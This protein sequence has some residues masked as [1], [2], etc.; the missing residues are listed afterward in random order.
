[1]ASFLSISVPTH[2]SSAHFLSSP[3]IPMSHFK[4]MV[5]LPVKCLS[6]G[7]TQNNTDS[8]VES[9]PPSSIFLTQKKES[10]SNSTYNLCAAIGSLGF[11][12]TGYLTYLKVTG[13]DAFCPIGGGNCG[14]ILNSD[15]AA[16]FGVP[17]PLIGMFAY[18]LVATLGVQLGRQNSIFGLG[19]TDGRM[20]LTATVTSMATASAYFLYI[21]STQFSGSACPYCLLS[22]AL[23]ST[24]FVAIIKDLGWQEIQKSVG[25][26]ICVAG[27][28]VAALN[29]SY[30]TIAPTSN[31]MADINLP[32]YQTEITTK[33]TPY[34]ISLAKHLRSIG[35]KMYGAFWCSH[36]LEQK[37]MFGQEGAKL[38]N[39]VE[40]FPN[41]FMKGTNMALECAVARL[42]G[43]PSWEIN[44]KILSGEKTFS[45]L[46]ELSGFVSE[47]FSPS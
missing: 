11:L 32:Y 36:C 10:I 12:E 20:I 7:P 26:Q 23:S 38:L 33:S 28:V 14:D 4:R 24:L 5:I 35:A 40:C 42:E 17:L 25:L 31:S 21:L 1:M 46:A 27:L 8:E 45:E 19:E 3:R 9:T 13:S 29:T 43:F 34:G 37:E 2:S 47:D 22:A 30:K 15:Y 18:G 6:G 44:G 39:Y 16:V 41:G